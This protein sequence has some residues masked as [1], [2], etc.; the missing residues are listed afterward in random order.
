M[1]I[2]KNHYLHDKVPFPKSGHNLVGPMDFLIFD[3]Y[4]IGHCIVE[5]IT[6]QLIKK[7]IILQMRRFK[8]ICKSN[9]T[10]TVKQVCSQRLVC[11]C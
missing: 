11:A 8:K 2:Q 7:G 6:K 3:L 9:F 10:Q 4:N 1:P 5:V